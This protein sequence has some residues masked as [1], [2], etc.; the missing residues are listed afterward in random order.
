METTPET[1]ETE[2]EEKVEEPTTTPL[3]DIANAAAERMEKANVETA[4]LQKAQAERDAK[5]ILGGR[6]AAGKEVKPKTQDN[7]D[8]DEANLFLEDEEI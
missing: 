6:A 8:Q 2:E 5:E 3:I 1:K 4:R 7:M